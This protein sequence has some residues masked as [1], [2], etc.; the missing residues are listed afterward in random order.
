MNKNV[1][2][3]LKKLQFQWQF[4]FVFVLMLTEKLYIHTASKVLGKRLRKLPA[5]IASCIKLK[6][7]QTIYG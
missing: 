6:K 2:V 5:A 3:A 1:F 4:K 7:I